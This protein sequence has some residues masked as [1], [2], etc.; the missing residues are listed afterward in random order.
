VG[1]DGFSAGAALSLRCATLL[2]LTAVGLL[3]TTVSLRFRYTEGT[4]PVRLARS[5][6]LKI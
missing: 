5:V 3:V 2:A 1:A 4:I 6:E